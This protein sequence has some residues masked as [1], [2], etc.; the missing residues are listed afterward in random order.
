MVMR[1]C[2]DLQGWTMEL[3]SALCYFFDLVLVTSKPASFIFCFIISFNSHSVCGDSTCG[4]QCKLRYRYILYAYRYINGFEVGWDRKLSE[5]IM[6]AGC[7]F[8]SINYSD[9]CLTSCLLFQYNLCFSLHAFILYW[10]PFGE[11][12]NFIANTCICC[13]DRKLDHNF[14]WSLRY[15]TTKRVW[16]DL[17]Q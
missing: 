11:F 3:M 4:K 8:Y 2:I 16:H 5:F 12:T 17:W 6:K 9:A 7:S 10:S 1:L 13:I 14:V 15:V